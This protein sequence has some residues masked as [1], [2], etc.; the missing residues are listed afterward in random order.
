MTFNAMVTELIIYDY[1]DTDEWGW[2]TFNCI[3]S[4]N[5]TAAAIQ[6]Q[7][8]SAGT[9]D[10]LVRINSAGGSVFD[11]FAIYNSLV[12][13]KAT[14]AKVNVSI[15]GLAASIASI[16]AM[17]GDEI[18]IQQ[19][20]MMM[21]HKPTID[22][23]WCGTMDATDLQREA[24]ALTR[25]EAVLN[26][27]YVTK[28]GL[29][30]TKIQ[31]MIDAETWLT[32]DLAVS[33][34][35]ATKKSN[36]VVEV[37]EMASS[38]FDHLFANSSTN[39]RAYAN[40]AFKIKNMSN[41]NEAILKAVNENITKTNSVLDWITN[42]FGLGAKPAGAMNASATLANGNP[43]YYN[44]ADE[45]AAGTQVFEDADMSKPMAD[46]T[47]DLNDNT[48]I[49]VADGVLTEV[50]PQ[51][52]P[53]SDRAELEALRNEVTELKGALNTANTAIES[54]NTR[55]DALKNVKSN[56]V[57]KPTADQF[58]QGGEESKGETAGEAAIRRNNERKNK[59]KAK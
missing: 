47:Y 13:H 36:T 30:A 9:N 28:T 26:D 17:A 7:I 6:G 21:V 14:G 15:D 34:G 25:I 16:I 51:E 42:K 23:F 44:D 10:L 5:L 1:I 52:L 3:G 37:M 12:E 45:F 31:N 22:P 18:T 48:E 50:A 55:I 56:Y 32:P 24:D 11:G 33:L 40:N 4:G 49:A 53:A 54:F 41:P 38:A 57:P 27:I 35:F 2:Q 29:G 20:A 46:G 43:I 58:N 19:A 59:A 8:A 39:I